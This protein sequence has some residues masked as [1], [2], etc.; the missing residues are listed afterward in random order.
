MGEIHPTLMGEIHPTLIGEIHPNTPGEIHPTLMGEIHPKTPG[1]IH[2]TL[3]GEIHP[4][5]PGE[6]HPRTLGEPHHNPIGEIHLNT[7]GET[8]LSTPGVPHPN[9]PG[10]LHH[11]VDKP[12]ESTL[13]QEWL[14]DNLESIWTFQPLEAHRSKN[15]LNKA[16]IHQSKDQILTLNKQQPEL[17]T[18]I[19]VD[20][21]HHGFKSAL[22]ILANVFR[23]I[24][25]IKLKLHNKGKHINCDIC[26]YEKNKIDRS[27]INKFEVLCTKSNAL[28]ELGPSSYEMWTAWTYT[29][30]LLSKEV[31]NTTSKSKLDSYIRDE[32][33]I[34]KSG[35]RLS[36]PELDVDN[37]ELAVFEN[38]SFIAPVALVTNP[39]IISLALHLHWEIL[40][41]PGIELHLGYMLSI[42]HVERLRTLIKKI[43]T[44]CIRCRLLLKKRYIG[45][46]G[47]QAKSCLVKA[48]PF[49]SI[50]MD[51]C[52]PF[53][54]HDS[55]KR[56]TTIK[57]YMLVIVCMLTGAVS[58][59]CLDSLS[60][61]SIM[62]SM[63]RHISRYGY[64]KLIYCDSQSSFLSLESLNFT[65]RDLKTNLWT[66]ER[67]V[68]EVSTPHAHMERG[69]VEQRVRV[70]REMLDKSREH[71]TKKSILDWETICA[72]TSNSLN[73]LPLAR[74][75]DE[76]DSP[77]SFICPN[78]FL[79]GRNNS[80]SLEFPI[81]DERNISKRLEDIQDTTD[82][83]IEY[84]AQNIH[85]YVPG[86]RIISGELP[87][88]GEVVLFI[89]EE[90]QRKRNEKF[91][92]GKITETFI[93]GR[94]NKVRITY[95]N[96]GETVNRETTRSV[97][98]I[99]IIMNLEDLD[100]GSAEQQL[101]NKANNKYLML[102]H[103]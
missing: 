49:Y 32:S 71:S 61:D 69:K 36:Y 65:I 23:F 101:V 14:E 55:V 78:H 95:R 67:I 75:C 90:S 31:S 87:Q 22:L 41:H 47:N 72:T 25:R 98:D 39:V 51:C 97:R 19:L 45:S 15:D 73:N 93:H 91:K 46:T 77:I 89:S 37:S 103:L 12:V 81:E 28:P 5:T 43:R 82:M 20:F 66:Q 34:L 53:L 10:V 8:H 16:P 88:A 6:I 74:H 33:E 42:V 3:M 40:N 59:V 54:A 99:V 9:N 11:N 38:T 29:C 94:S 58:I 17:D 57:A 86:K 64:A 1:E 76:T 62:S 26:D 80:R 7:Q 30:K 85:K 56:R 4:K 13:N 27:Y 35:G 92:Y 68:L 63:L 2:P 24:Q 102:K 44:S 50:Q 84:L 60:T 70:I 52:G 48:P 83:M 100:F 18:V 96:S 79:L 21:K